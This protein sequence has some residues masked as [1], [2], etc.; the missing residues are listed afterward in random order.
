MRKL[1]ILIVFITPIIA[2]AQVPGYMGKRNGVSLTLSSF[3]GYNNADEYVPGSEM[4]INLRPTIS[5]E[6]LFSHN[7][8]MGIDYNYISPRISNYS[9][10]KN[11]TDSVS[12][13]IV[14]TGFYGD[15]RIRAQMF[16]WYFQ[17]FNTKKFGAIA[18]IGR[19]NRFELMI[20]TATFKTINSKEVSS[21]PIYADFDIQVDQVEDISKLIPATKFILLYSFGRQMPLSENYLINF[22]TQIGYEFDQAGK[23]GGERGTAHYINDDMY[24]RV[25]GA[26]FLNIQIGLQWLW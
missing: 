12:G 20:Y 11:E 13:E 17:F 10:F 24:E 21:N 1:V 4:T 23:Y 5:V 8:M 6:R 14:Q 25:S 19:Y 2:I 26:M 15:V 9:T 3:V 7:F 18:P 22:G 16:G